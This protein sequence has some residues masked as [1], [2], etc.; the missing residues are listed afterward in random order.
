MCK[1]WGERGRPA[2]W[3]VLLRAVRR[4]GKLGGG[5]ADG[6]GHG[7]ACRRHFALGIRPVP[8]A[9][10]TRPAP[11]IGTT[12]HP[13]CVGGTGAGTRDHPG[14]CIAP[15]VGDRRP[16]PRRPLRRLIDPAG[17]RPGVLAKLSSGRGGFCRRFCSTADVP[18]WVDSKDPTLILSD[19]NICL[20]IW[21]YLTKILLGIK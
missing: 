4:P 17:A 16:A 21:M 14:L 3:R 18:I 2:R 9:H 12:A 6:P 20:V 15:G 10:P 8:H 5:G 7:R 1:M 11:G 13:R 19:I